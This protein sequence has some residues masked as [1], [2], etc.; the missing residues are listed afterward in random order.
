[1]AFIG[2]FGGASGREICASTNLRERNDD[3]G[4]PANW[5]DSFM[6]AYASSDPFEDIARSPAHLFN[7]V[8][9]RETTRSF[10]PLVAT[11]ISKQR[12]TNP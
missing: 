9:A 5:Q 10:G 12:A 7:V 3:G 1:M 2:A 4:P 8:D 6:S 11:M